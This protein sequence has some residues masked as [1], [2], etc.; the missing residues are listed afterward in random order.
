MGGRCTGGASIG[1]TPART[2]A[3][4]TINDTDVLVSGVSGDFAVKNT[5]LWVGFLRLIS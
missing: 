1:D 4:H 2:Q 3:Q 5:S